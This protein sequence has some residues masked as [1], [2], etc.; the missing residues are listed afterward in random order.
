MTKHVIFL[1]HGMGRYGT[2]KDGK[3]KP[4]QEGW[5]DEAEKALAEIHDKF[6]KDTLG[7]GV[8]FKDRFKVVRIEYDSILD[9]FRH[10]WQLQAKEW[11]K[12]GLTG[13]A[14]DLRT[15]FQG[16]SDEAF[17]WTHVADVA[18][19]VA[20]TVRAHVQARFSKLVFEGLVEAAKEVQQ[21]GDVL[22][23]SVIAHSLGTAVTHDT[24]AR[25]E[26]LA[27]K[28]P[29]LSA[30]WTPPR[31]VCMAANV[32][33]VLTDDDLGVYGNELAPTGPDKPNWYLNCNHQLDPFVRV[34]PFAPTAG[35]WVAPGSAYRDLSGL[36]EYYL[37]EEVAEWLRDGEDLDKFAAVVPHG[38]THYMRQPRV[39][40]VLW[41]CLL[42][43][44]PFEWSPI[45]EP[46]VRK[47]Y[48]ADRR[49]AIRDAIAPE[50]EKALAPLGSGPKTIKTTLEGL[51]GVLKRLG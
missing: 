9:R 35:G 14:A 11:G 16:N 15:F 38:F 12:L 33:R 42:G 23:W 43:R 19:Y 6:V 27:D 39:A 51:S 48:A 8:A 17:L 31:V 29:T 10:D 37:V 46:A 50:L 47:A 41:P 36:S 25:L 21:E 26:K 7:E 34:D 18:L 32:A 3:Y 24:L 28:D 2:F 45:I 30:V 40:A 22:R 5:F 4:D 44:P 20:P 1:V 13:L 49:D